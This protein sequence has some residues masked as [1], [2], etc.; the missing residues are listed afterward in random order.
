MSESVADLFKSKGLLRWWEQPD[1]QDFNGRTEWGTDF[2]VPANTP[3]GAIE[4]GKVVYA[5]EA[6]GHPG[7]S[8]GHIVIVE[9]PDGRAWE[10]L[11]L[12]QSTVKAGDHIQ[13]GDVVGVSGGC[14]ASGYS[15]N[16][17]QCSWRD[18]FST[19]PHIEV[20]HTDTFNP[21]GAPWNMTWTN[22]KALI[23]ATAGDAPHSNGA[24]FNGLAAGEGGNISAGPFSIDAGPWVELLIRAGLV[25]GGFVFILAAVAIFVQGNSHVET[26]ES[27]VGK[28]ATTAA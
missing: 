27:G 25:L 7:S 14:P 10:Y 20:R 15:G 17:S 16:P 9:T 3:V 21:S 19:N 11:H 4:G 26:V 13:P 2:A 12:R 5:A 1:T 24:L 18:S 23:F 28:V 22:P 8:L 6:P